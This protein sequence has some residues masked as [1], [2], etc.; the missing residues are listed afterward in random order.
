VARA[1]SLY[2][3]VLTPRAL[4]DGDLEAMAVLQAIAIRSLESRTPTGN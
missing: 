3:S 1:D 4:A 2:R